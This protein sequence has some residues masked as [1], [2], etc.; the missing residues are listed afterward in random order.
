MKINILL[1][2]LFAFLGL[3]SRLFAQTE[4][5][6][7]S[8]VKFVGIYNSTLQKYAK[9]SA[10]DNK[11]N[12]K[13]LTKL[14][15]TLAD[16][17]TGRIKLIK[18][19]CDTKAADSVNVLEKLTTPKSGFFLPIFGEKI[20]YGETLS[21]SNESGSNTEKLNYNEINKCF[22]Y[23]TFHNGPVQYGYLINVKIVK[24]LPK[25]FEIEHFECN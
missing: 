17:T 24:G 3:N 23:S 22:Y 8:F 1:F 6:V 10:E 20:R 16:M 9:L 14:A 18:S 21:S 25:I 11:K 5:E 19:D 4:E 7:K 2:V 13:E 15:K 12:K